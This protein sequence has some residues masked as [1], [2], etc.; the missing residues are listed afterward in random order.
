MDGQTSKWTSSGNLFVGLNGSG[1]LTIVNGS[2]V[3]ALPV[4]IAKN[5]DSAGT[6]NI[7]AAANSAAAAPGILQTPTVN[8]GNGSATLVFNHTSSRYEFAPFWQAR[9]VR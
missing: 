1:D 7:G 8:F 5:K 6:I 9:P 2:T 4:Y 3:A